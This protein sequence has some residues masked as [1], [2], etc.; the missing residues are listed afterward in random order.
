M[1]DCVAAEWLHGAVRGV[2]LCTSDESERESMLTALA[3]LTG[4]PV[5]TGPL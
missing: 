1:L 3:G 5:H 4:V 2:L